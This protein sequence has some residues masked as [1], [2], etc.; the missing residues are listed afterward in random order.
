MRDRVGHEDRESA[1]SSLPMKFLRFAVAIV[2]V[3]FGF[4]RSRRAMGLAAFIAMIAL[5]VWTS[6]NRWGV[7]IALHYLSRVW[8]PEPTDP[9]PP[10][11]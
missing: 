2:L 5:L 10:P 1:L 7:G 6:P 11:F 9:I 4:A 8:C 3:Y